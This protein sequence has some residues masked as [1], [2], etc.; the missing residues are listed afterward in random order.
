MIFVNEKIVNLQGNVV[1][2]I[3]PEFS[4]AVSAV[5]RACID[6]LSRSNKDHDA[7]EKLAAGFV[8]A[9]VKVGIERYEDGEVA[10]ESF[11]SEEN[12]GQ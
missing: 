11:E 12:P 10:Y 3:G 4:R 9:C 2:E 8:Y 7:I 6:S 1:E 5:Y